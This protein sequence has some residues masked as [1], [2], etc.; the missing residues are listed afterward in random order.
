LRAQTLPKDDVKK[1][2]KLFEKLLI[3]GREFYKPPS[4]SK[5]L[6]GAKSFQ[7]AS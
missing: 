7:R 2:A 4:N 1:L 6:A 5:K 3:E